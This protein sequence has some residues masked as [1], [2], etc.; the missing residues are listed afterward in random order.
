MKQ[1]LQLK[2]SQ[3]IFAVLLNVSLKTIQSWEQ[4]VNTPSGS[5]LRLLWLAKQRPD[6]F[7]SLLPRC[8]G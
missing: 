5:A 3:H 6:I 4:S 2:L 8:T 1:T 7:K